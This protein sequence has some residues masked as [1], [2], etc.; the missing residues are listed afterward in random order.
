MTLCGR[1]EAEGLAVIDAVGRPETAGGAVLRVAGGGWLVAK[2]EMPVVGWWPNLNWSTG[3][4]V[5]TYICIC[6]LQVVTSQF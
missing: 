6:Q 1:L 2:F 4:S 3:Q 5:I